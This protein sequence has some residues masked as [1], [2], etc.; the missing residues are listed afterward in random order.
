MAKSL[1]R[2]H[3][4]N[5]TPHL[6]TGRVAP[7]TPLKARPF[8]RTHLNRAQLNH[9]LW[10]GWCVQLGAVFLCLDVA[11]VITVAFS[12]FT[13]K[14]CFRS[15]LLLLWWRWYPSCFWNGPIGFVE[16]SLNFDT[17]KLC[18]DPSKIIFCHS[19]AQT[20]QVH[21]TPSK[22]KRVSCQNKCC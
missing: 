11:L 22:W 15:M 16:P 19:D 18:K 9:V 8:N 2:S 21:V 5:A 7:E 4:K 20:T 13:S 12:K 17:L 10:N 3:L 6:L 1:R 14:T